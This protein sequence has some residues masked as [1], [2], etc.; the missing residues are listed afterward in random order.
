MGRDWLLVT[1]YSLFVI[2]DSLF[3]I[4][5]SLFVIGDSL[6]V[7]RYSLFV[8]RYSLFVIRC[9]VL[10]ICYLLFGIR[11]L[12][13]AAS[14]RLFPFNFFV[15]TEFT[16]GDPCQPGLP[17]AIHRFP[18]AR[19]PSPQRNPASQLLTILPVAKF[20]EFFVAR[21]FIPRFSGSPDLPG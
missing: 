4:G 10:V 20:S 16:S 5:D 1:R 21:G 11:D 17:A 12:L 6:L 7:I 13:G 14:R 8:T 9:S 18:R 19:H 3:V 2:G 15:A